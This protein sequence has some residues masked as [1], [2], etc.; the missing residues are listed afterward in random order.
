MGKKHEACLSTVPNEILPI[1]VMFGSYPAGRPRHRHPR[2][3]VGGYRRKNGRLI[4]QTTNLLQID[5][6]GAPQPTYIGIY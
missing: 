3:N 4:I 1:T 6:L 5:I 2:C